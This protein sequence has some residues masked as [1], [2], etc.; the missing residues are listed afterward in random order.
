VKT[1]N[2][3]TPLHVRYSP[4]P[5]KQGKKGKQKQ[6]KAHHFVKDSSVYVSFCFF[7]S[8]SGDVSMIIDVENGICF[9]DSTI[10]DSM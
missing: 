8:N 2:I 4:P 10:W 1:R 6:L 3:P 9:N 7:F 5:P